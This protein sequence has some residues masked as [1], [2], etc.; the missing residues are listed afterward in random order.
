[1]FTNVRYGPLAE[2]IVE[3]LHLHGRMRLSQLTDILGQ[4]EA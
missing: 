3:Q 1:M 2:R 4:D